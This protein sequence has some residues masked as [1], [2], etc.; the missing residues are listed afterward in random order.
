MRT[1]KDLWAGSSCPVVPVTALK[2]EGPFNTTLD[3]RET[4]GNLR[5][6][7]R[8]RGWQEGGHCISPRAESTEVT[9]DWG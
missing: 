3:Y 7:S 5:H 6:L 4:K 2:S 1:I 8:G 9:N